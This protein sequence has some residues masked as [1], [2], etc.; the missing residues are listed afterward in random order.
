MDSIASPPDISTAS[1]SFTGGAVELLRLGQSLWVNHDDTCVCRVHDFL[2]LS[3]HGFAD[4]KQQPLLVEVPEVLSLQEVEKRHVL[5]MLERFKW[6]KSHVARLL[7]IE[8]ST[9]DRKLTKW[10]MNRPDACK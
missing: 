10:E 5:G 3:H 6:N 1:L 4:P 9:L 8:R 2:S 7:E